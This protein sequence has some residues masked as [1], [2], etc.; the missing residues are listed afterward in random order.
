MTTTVDMTTLDCPYG[1]GEKLVVNEDGKA[2]CPTDS[3]PLGWAD[4]C[5][6]CTAYFPHAD[7]V[8]D[9]AWDVVRGE[10]ERL[11]YL[12]QERAKYAVLVDEAEGL[13]D[14][15]TKLANRIGEQHG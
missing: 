3:G 15:A 6:G 1:C 7:A 12:Y 4:E 5:E 9:A 10:K 14:R 11:S 2:K 8:V 13:V